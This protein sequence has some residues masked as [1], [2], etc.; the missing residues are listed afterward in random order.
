METI[1]MTRQSRVDGRRV[2]RVEST[3]L[4]LFQVS[5]SGESAIEDDHKANLSQWNDA[6]QGQRSRIARRLAL[7]DAQLGLA[8]SRPVL[9]VVGSR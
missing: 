6:L 7:I 8:E 3:L 5:S 2:S 1:G 9:A 4:R